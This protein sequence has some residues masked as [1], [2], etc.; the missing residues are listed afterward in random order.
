[1]SDFARLRSDGTA[2]GTVYD[3]A[4]T[5]S[6][7]GEELWWPPASSAGIVV[8]EQ[9]AL[10]LAPLLATANVLA[11]DVA[12]LPLQVYQGRG[13]EGRREAKDHSN[14]RL[15]SRSPNG[16]TTPVRW[17]KA[18]IAHAL[19]YGN[20]YAEIQRTGRGAPYRLHLLDPGTTRVERRADQL[21][22]RLVNGKWL[23]S[24]NVLHIAGLSF[25]GLSGYNFVRLLHQGI[26]LGLAAEGFGA[27][28]FANGSEPG[29]VIETPKR[30]SGEGVKN[31]RAGWEDKHRGPGKRHRVAVLE[32]GA[33]FK[34]TSTDPEKS[35]L[36]ETRKFQVND[37]TRPWRVP[38]HKIGDYSQSHL[39]N[40]EASNLD[41]LMTALIGWLEEIEQECNLKLFTEAEW[42]QGFYVEHNVNALLR[43]DIS[44][45]YEA[46]GK[47]LND[48]WL[49]RDEVRR[50][51]NLN[52]IGAESG[53][54]KYLVQAQMVPLSE[55]GSAFDRPASAGTTD[56][57]S[58]AAFTADQVGALRGLL[59]SVAAD[60]LPADA[61]WQMIRTAYPS[62]KPDEID[63]LV[64]PVLSYRPAALR[65]E[66]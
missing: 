45:R 15:L 40:I 55:A 65:P 34:A 8:T 18:W 7:A 28:Y 25:D 63:A 52:P 36:L 24:Q 12:T 41:Y 13:E 32:E 17:R 43:G 61:C 38:P 4:E 6:V 49:N 3:Q 50:R 20:G 29:G 58:R 21:G 64:N 35:Q 53:G 54:E 46:Y 37:V 56:P 48:G 10:Q 33:S 27:D 47:A 42:S 62:L 44:S 30:L 9:T 60:E 59:R 14:S 39:A 66:S 1:M 11:T 31:L 16:E 22:Y 26:G 23:T 51:E 57:E 2:A 5:R 19:L